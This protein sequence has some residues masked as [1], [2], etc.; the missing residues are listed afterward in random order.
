MFDVIHSELKRLGAED[1]QVEKDSRP[2]PS[3]VAM[4][5]VTIDTR[6]CAATQDGFLEMLRS[7]PDGSGTHAIAA[8]IESRSIHAEPWI[9]CFH[10]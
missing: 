6:S 9:T 2:G 10:Q 5:K 1:V 7:L 3:P 4:I 8:E